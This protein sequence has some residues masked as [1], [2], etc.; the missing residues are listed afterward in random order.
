MGFQFSVAQ[1]GV[2]PVVFHYGPTLNIL[3]QGD[4]YMRTQTLNVTLE[5]SEAPNTP[6]IEVQESDISCKGSF[7][8]SSGT[9]SLSSVGST[10]VSGTCQYRKSI[11]LSSGFSTMFQVT[12]TVHPNWTSSTM[13]HGLAF[14]LTAVDTSTLPDETGWYLNS[15]FNG[16]ASTGHYSV[17]EIDLIHDIL[18]HVYVVVD[19]NVTSFQN[20]TSYD[21]WGL[22][23]DLSIAESDHGQVPLSV[24][25]NYDGDTNILE[26]S[27]DL[28][29][30][31]GIYVQNAMF[32]PRPA[33]IVSTIVNLTEKFSNFTAFGMSPV[34]M[35]GFAASVSNSLNSSSALDSS[36]GNGVEYIINAW[37][38]NSNGSAP[39]MPVTDKPS[40]RPSLPPA[41][42]ILLADPS[43]FVFLALVLT[44][45]GLYRRNARLVAQLGK[46]KIEEGLLDKGHPQN[47]KYGALSS[48]TKGFSS[49]ELLGAGGLGSVYKGKLVL[50]GDDKPTEIA[51]KRISSTSSQGAQEFL[52]EVRIIGQAQHRNLVRLLGW[53]H[54]RGELLLVYDYMPNGSVDQHL[55]SVRNEDRNDASG[56]PILTWSRR[57]KIMSGVAEALTYLHEGWEK[58]VFH[59]DVKCSNVMLDRDFNARLGDFGLARLSE[60]DTAPP[61]TAVLA[62]TRGYMAPELFYTLKATEK[63][64]V[65]SFGAMVLEVANGKK[66][67]LPPADREASD[68]VLRV[69]WV[70]DL[71]KEDALLEAADGR[72]QSAYDRGEM[73]MFLKI[74]LLCSHP[75]PNERPSMREVVNIW[76]GIARFPPLPR[77]RPVPFQPVSTERHD[78]TSDRVTGGLSPQ[79]ETMHTTLA[80]I[81]KGESIQLDNLADHIPDGGDSRST[82]RN[83]PTPIASLPY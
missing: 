22:E 48:A 14:I 19:Q 55:F 68:H 67:I 59:R 11:Q 47:F 29:R 30:F 24:W 54:E 64:D 81:E 72:L 5:V 32:D 51:V 44:I 69:D 34:L 17:V 82:L 2:C 58:R 15:T 53:C 31:N 1:V 56:D 77:W 27:V 43:I 23:S 39:D 13:D 36:S 40:S 73:I 78:H 74:G 45:Y 75:D 8:H 16:L 12:I 21:P 20:G 28:W 60:H 49:S 38:F 37:T 83:R 6:I 10:N 46:H 79:S 71:Y 7:S 66:S 62:G 18:Q 50:K 57:L 70:W 3:D 33:P 61:S 4:D 63:T 26:V 35:F 76:K 42:I 52:A 65:Y 25:V 41:G 9:L 80:S